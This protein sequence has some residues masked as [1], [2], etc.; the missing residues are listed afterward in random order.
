MGQL[1][2]AD[3]FHATDDFFDPPGGLEDL[4][5]APAPRGVKS[6]LQQL[7][8]AHDHGQRVVD[9]VRRRRGEARDVPQ[10]V[11]LPYRGLGLL[12]LGDVRA[13]DDAPMTR[14]AGSSVGDTVIDTSIRRP[15]RATRTVS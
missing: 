15:S 11:P 2:P 12:A 7:R 14:P 4:L 10:G 8:L 3:A 6:L 13:I 1:E 5:N 9:L